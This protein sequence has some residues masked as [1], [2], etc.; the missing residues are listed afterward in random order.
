MIQNKIYITYVLQNG[1][2]QQYIIDNATG[3]TIKN[4]SLKTMRG[5]SIVIPPLSIQ[6]NIV[7]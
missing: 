4:V 5:Y 7:K 6:Q 1:D 2:F 3:A